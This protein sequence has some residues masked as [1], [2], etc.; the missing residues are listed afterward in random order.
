MTK[1]EMLNKQLTE[2]IAQA[3]NIVKAI[4]ETNTDKATLDYGREMVF[5]IKVLKDRIA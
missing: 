3:E 5:D 2:L 1:Q 4:N